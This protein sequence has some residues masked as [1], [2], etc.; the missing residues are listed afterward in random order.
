MGPLRNRQS[1]AEKCRCRLSILKIP[2][3]AF[4]TVLLILHLKSGTEENS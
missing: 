3:L 1:L 4:K 2:M